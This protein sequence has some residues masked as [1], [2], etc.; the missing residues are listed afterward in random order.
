MIGNRKFRTFNVIDDCSREVLA[1]EQGRRAIDTS[2]SSKRI[3][4]VLERIGLSRGF[5]KAI[6]SDNVPRGVRQNLRRKILL[7]GVLIET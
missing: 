1:I 4:R 3:T 2:L 5:P 6:R 7:L